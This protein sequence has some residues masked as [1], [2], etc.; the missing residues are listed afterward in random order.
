MTATATLEQSIEQDLLNRLERKGLTRAK[1]ESITNLLPP[2]GQHYLCTE[3]RDNPN[4]LQELGHTY[5]GNLQERFGTGFIE[6][7]EIRAQLLA[8]A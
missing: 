8:A 5:P 1:A 7:D 4:A 3:L 6:A 2:A